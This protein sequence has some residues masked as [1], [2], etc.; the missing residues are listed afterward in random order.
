MFPPQEVIQGLKNCQAITFS[1]TVARNHQ[2]TKAGFCK[3]KFVQSYIKCTTHCTIQVIG[4][5]QSS[6]F[7]LF[8]QG[9]KSKLQA[10]VLAVVTFAYKLCPVVYADI[11]G[12]NATT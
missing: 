6:V 10:P 1:H 7:T 3:T 4:S 9:Q 5:F 11:V 2:F 8:A 12:V